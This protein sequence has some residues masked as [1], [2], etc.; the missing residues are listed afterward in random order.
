MTNARCR[1]ICWLPTWNKNRDRMG[2]EHLLL[3]EGVADSV[4]LAFDEE[5]GPFRLTYRLTWDASWRL[6]DAELTL[7]TERA[8]RSLNLQTDGQGHWRHRDGAAID[9]LD[10]CLDIDIWPTPFTNAFPIRREPMAIGE[11]RE[12]RMAWIFAPDLTVK[13]QP[14]AYTRLA[15]RLYLFESLDGSGF[16]A[17]L[18]VDEDGIVLD[19]PDLFRRCS[20]AASPV[21]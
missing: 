19:Y 15:D 18:P 1:T 21:R 8:T 11:R 5:H 17:G 9:Y 14:Q 10:G 3:S 6:R 2:L 4:V 20:S 12:F 16:K 13:A 7:A